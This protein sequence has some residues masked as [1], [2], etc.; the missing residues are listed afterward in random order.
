MLAVGDSVPLL[1]A[2]HAVVRVAVTPLFSGHV[3]QATLASISAAQTPTTPSPSSA[4]STAAMANRPGIELVQQ[5]LAELELALASCRHNVQ[6]DRVD[7]EFHKDIVQAAAAV[8]TAHGRALKVD[9]LASRLEDATFSNS[10]QACVNRWIVSLRKLVGHKRLAEM[11]DE[12]TT[13]QE[14]TF[15]SEMDAAMRHVVA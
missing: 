11:P 1:D 12:S 15:W 13:M 14:L 4:S 8:Q 9:D 10:V 6:I 2:L 5:K 7:L 3:A